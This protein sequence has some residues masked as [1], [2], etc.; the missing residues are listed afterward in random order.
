[1]LVKNIRSSLITSSADKNDAVG[2]DGGFQG[3]NYFILL[4]MI[5]S[6]LF[7]R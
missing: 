3:D 2:K 1:M 6:F 5:P 4:K 7:D